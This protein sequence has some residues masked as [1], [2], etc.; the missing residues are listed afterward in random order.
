MQRV[1]VPAFFL[2]F[3]G[4][5]SLPI[6]KS[7]YTCDQEV[8]TK[9]VLTSSLCHEIHTFRPFSKEQS[10]ATTETTQKLNF[11]QEKQTLKYVSGMYQNTTQPSPEVIKHFSYSTQ[12]GMKFILLIIVK[13]STWLAF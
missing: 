9:G 5:K 13:M 1:I 6:L 11:V 10:G 4:L 7:S 3:Q 12:L 8:T 2:H